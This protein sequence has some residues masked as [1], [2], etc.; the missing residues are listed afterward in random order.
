[1]QYYQ[2][3]SMDDIELILILLSIIIYMLPNVLTELLYKWN[4]IQIKL[5]PIEWNYICQ[6]LYHSFLVILEIIMVYTFSSLNRDVILGI[7]LIT[8]VLQIFEQ[9]NNYHESFYLLWLTSIINK[10]NYI[11]ELLMQGVEGK[12]SNMQKIKS[13]KTN[14]VVSDTE[15]EWKLNSVLARHEGIFLEDSLFIS[16]FVSSIL[17][18][19][20]YQYDLMFIRW[21]STLDG[22]MDDNMTNMV[23]KLLEQTSF[24]CQYF[25]R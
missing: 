23:L 16:H 9:S 18:Q 19:L 10:N 4:S 1:M 6:K 2:A 22:S 3:Q 25:Q 5:F 11:K 13:D 24:I 7:R 20:H 12:G 14:N 21:N 15:N 17:Y 8:E